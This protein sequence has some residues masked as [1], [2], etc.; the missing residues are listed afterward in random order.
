MKNLV[1]YLCDP[2][3]VYLKRLNSFIL[4]Q[5]Y[6]PFVVRTY[7]GLSQITGSEDRPVWLMLSSSLWD[8]CGDTVPMVELL[9]NGNFSGIVFL[10][11]GNLPGRTDIEQAFAGRADMFIVDKYQSAGQIYQRL[12]DICGAK[13]DL[14]IRLGVSRK[15]RTKL[16]GI[17]SPDHKCLQSAFALEKARHT[18]RDK[19]RLYITFEECIRAQTQTRGL[20]QIILALREYFDQLQTGGSPDGCLGGAQ[21]CPEKFCVTDMVKDQADHEELLDLLAPAACPYDLLEIQDEEWYCWI[22]EL[23]EQG[24]YFSIIV[25]FGNGIPALC[26][27]ELCEKIYIPQV[28]GDKNTGEELKNMLEFMGKSEISQKV[29]PVLLEGVQYGLL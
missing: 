23:M 26:L 14:L 6:S 17:Y 3:V 25:N 1:L 2:D 24:G 22:L 18:D 20:S 27:M 16:T 12:L 10:D 19:P 4:R 9:E 29:E 5:E 13:G 28:S 11:E 7:T 21:D 15:V 8:D